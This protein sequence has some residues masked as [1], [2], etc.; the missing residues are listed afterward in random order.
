MVLRRSI[1]ELELPR[2]GGARFGKVAAPMLPY[3]PMLARRALEHIF[4][5]DEVTPGALLKTDNRRKAW[6]FYWT[7]EELG[8]VMLSRHSSWRL[9]EMLEERG[10]RK[11]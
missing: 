1:R 11:V 8:L 9:N 3:Q 2:E 4:Y 7:V 5:T 6:V 10:A